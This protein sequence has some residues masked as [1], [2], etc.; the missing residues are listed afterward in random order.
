MD[1]SIPVETVFILRRSRVFAQ[2][3]LTQMLCC[4]GY[5]QKTELE[6]GPTWKQ[7]EIFIEFERKRKSFSEIVSSSPTNIPSSLKYE[8]HLSRQYS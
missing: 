8:P 7:K 3:V 2:A 1:I 6:L 5:V 4:H